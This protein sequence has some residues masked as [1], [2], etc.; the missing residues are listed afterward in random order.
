MN[1][2]NTTIEPHL[3]AILNDTSSTFAVPT[4]IE[5]PPLQKPSISKTLCQP[6]H[7]QLAI[8][9]LKREKG[10]SLQ[11]N[12]NQAS[13]LSTVDDEISLK[14]VNKGLSNSKVECT[15]GDSSRQSLSK[16]LDISDCENLYLSKKR[17][18][19][20]S[21]KDEFV[22]LPRPTKE[23]KTAKQVVPPIIIGLFQPP[24]QSTLF[25]P[26][27]SSCFH[28][29]R[30][31]NSLNTIPLSTKLPKRVQGNKHDHVIVRHST[32]RS[33]IKKKKNVA[34]RKKWTEEETN[35]LLLGVHKHGVGC[36]SDI[37]SDSCFV[38]N[39]RSSSDL[40]DRW[41]TCC[42]DELR[43]RTSTSVDGMKK[44]T[45]ENTRS[46]LNPDEVLIQ[47]E[48]KL[49]ESDL[50]T[51]SVTASRKKRCHRKN[52]EDL[53]QLG[54][55]GLIRQSS[56]RERRQFTQEEDYA[57]LEGYKT[58]GP[59][60]SKIQKDP[61]LNLQSRQ[62]TD[63]R[64]RFRNKFKDKFLEIKRNNIPLDIPKNVCKNKN[65]RNIFGKDNYVR[66]NQVS[67]KNNSFRSIQSTLQSLPSRD[68]LRI[69]EIISTEPFSTM[70]DRPPIDSVE[71]SPFNQFPDWSQSSATSYSNIIGDM[72]I[73]R[74]IIEQNWSSFPLR[75]EKQASPDVNNLLLPGSGSFQQLP[76]FFSISN[77]ADDL[78][79][80]PFC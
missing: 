14:N 32:V 58:Y 51:N 22:Q 67:T 47:D 64:D 15:K 2:C 78:V 63:L 72:D 60:W 11:L 8:R 43:K 30:G 24:P 3:I 70:I 80:Q 37:L 6:P 1:S 75:K 73:S 27:A 29:S 7:P 69:Q 41:R 62:P 40:K 56:R 54:I 74:S 35:N 42:P 59:A 50:I 17:N 33:G 53:F 4:Y 61:R 48:S 19:M 5:L 66:S 25:P 31:R 26:I 18:L 13:V 12:S 71:N 57:I 44:G 45:S 49:N 68:G 20:N 21:N 9:E 46:C 10:A 79:G 36:W 55:K 52:L 39:D 77:E 76:S 38:F 65:A 28:D 16:I 34:T 23:Q